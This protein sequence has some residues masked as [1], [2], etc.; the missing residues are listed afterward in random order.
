MIPIGMIEA[1]K[2]KAP[3][4]NNDFV[5]QD[6]ILSRL[7]STMYSHEKIKQS[8]VF[9]GGTADSLRSEIEKSFHDHAS[10]RSDPMLYKLYLRDG[11]ESRVVKSMF[12]NFIKNNY[13][14]IIPE[15]KPYDVFVRLIEIK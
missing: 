7:L 13:P 12:R 3:W 2:S 14:D 10:S 11:F 5:E 6:L 4:S 8:L 15:I 9:K 1:W